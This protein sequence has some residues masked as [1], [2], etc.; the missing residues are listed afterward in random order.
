MTKIFFSWQS[1]TPSNG[2][3]NFIERALE[4]AIGQVSKDIE[5]EE[6]IRESLSVDRDTRGEPGQPPVVDTIFR[7]IEGAAIFV[8]DIT[9]IARRSDGE[10]VPNPNVLIEYGYAVKSISN[11]RIIMVMNEAY[12]HPRDGLPFDMKHL[13]W[14]ITYNVPE[15]ADEETKKAEREK[16]VRQLVDA[17]RSI[18][19]SVEYRGVINTKTILLPFVGVEPKDG[20]ARFR[21]RGE[22]IGINSDNARWRESEMVFLKDG[23]AIWLRVMPKG[24]L[25]KSWST[26]ELKQTATS[27][28][29][30]LLPLRRG[31]SSYSYV[32]A[33][34]GFGVYVANNRDDKTCGV[35]FA[36]TTGEIW[37]ADSCLVSDGRD[38]RTGKPGIPTMEDE[39]KAALNQY[40]NYLQEIGVHRPLRW[41]G[42]Y[43]GIRGMGLYY[44]PPKGRHFIL[45]GPYGASASDIVQCEGVLEDGM[46]IY[47]S[48]RPL[49]VKLFDVCGIKREEYLDLMDN[50]N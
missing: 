5:I 32:R 41:I 17:I 15:G 14:P 12:G 49:F 31:Y 10:C 28:N 48:L 34:D 36:F 20:P 1:D 3:R 47:E 9:A 35:V 38:D 2:G 21:V 40:E 13:R 29:L 19:D 11:N 7:K 6:S 8:P 42:G 37:S 33:E 24:N 4:K 27:G 43:E 50:P 39:F 44:P 22:P 26:M 46:T 16:L 18:L 45:P 30:K 25:Q 23:P